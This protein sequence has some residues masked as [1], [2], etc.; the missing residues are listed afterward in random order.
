VGLYESIVEDDKI[1]EP[2]TI[3]VKILEKIAE[4][5]K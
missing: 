4:N 3:S 2:M 5:L 1:N